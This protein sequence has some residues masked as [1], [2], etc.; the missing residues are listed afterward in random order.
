MQTKD[1]QRAPQRP[2]GSETNVSRR[3]SSSSKSNLYVLGVF[4]HRLALADRWT[5]DS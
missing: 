3:F 1:Q 4:G 5:G 2:D